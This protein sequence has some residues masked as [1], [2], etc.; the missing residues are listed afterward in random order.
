MIPMETRVLE[1]LIC[2]CDCC[3]VDRFALLV[4]GLLL[5]AMQFH[6]GL[7]REFEVFR[8]TTVT[9]VKSSDGTF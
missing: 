8:N 4:A 3:V 5:L 2:Y 1:Y 9:A 7:Q 6:H